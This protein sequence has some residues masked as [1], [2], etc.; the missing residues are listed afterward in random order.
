MAMVAERGDEFACGLLLGHLEDPDHKVKK[1][2]KE[3]LK[4]LGRADS[5]SL[6]A[7]GHAER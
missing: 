7:A 2:V 6:R 4:L 3:S 5:R 1:A